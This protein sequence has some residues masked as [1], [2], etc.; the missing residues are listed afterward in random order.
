MPTPKAR[1]G[2][3]LAF[4]ICIGSQEPLFSLGIY[5]K[6]AA[7]V[8]ACETLH[9]RSKLWST[10]IWQKQEQ[11]GRVHGDAIYA[12]CKPHKLQHLF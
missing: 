2:F 7:V 4:L 1:P 10:T 3:M 11:R 12:H 5:I 9:P 6:H 8:D